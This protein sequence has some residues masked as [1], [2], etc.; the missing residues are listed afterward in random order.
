MYNVYVCVCV[1]VCVWRIAC[2]ASSREA[3]EEEWKRSLEHWNPRFSHLR[4]N[5]PSM[6]ATHTHVCT[7]SHKHKDKRHICHIHVCT[8]T[9]A[10][11]H[12]DNILKNKHI[13]RS[14][15]QHPRHKHVCVRALFCHEQR[16]QYRKN[17]QET[18]KE[19]VFT[20]RAGT[21]SNTYKPSYTD[22]KAK[23]RAQ[24]DFETQSDMQTQNTSTPDGHIYFSRL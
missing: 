1:C 8:Y 22:M 21:H 17:T 24:T 9:H 19:S 3:I 4:R 12:K 20:K 11:S 2:G 7:H 13:P 14:V 16:H 10:N 15:L 18:T 6:R 23:T 5:V